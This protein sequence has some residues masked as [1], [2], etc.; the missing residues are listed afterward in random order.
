MSH[1]ER[2][3]YWNNRWTGEGFGW[4]NDQALILVADQVLGGFPG[5][6]TLEVASGRGVD[7]LRLAQMGAGAYVADFSRGALEITRL[8]ASQ[9]KVSIQITQADA[10]R[11]PFASNYFDLVFS[12]GLLEHPGDREEFLREQVRVV[13]PGGY[14]IVDMPNKYCLQTPIRDVQVLL[15]LWPQ[16]KEYPMSYWELKG[17]ME[18]AGLTPIR[19]YGWDLLPLLHLG[20][21]DRM[22]GKWVQRVDQ[23][24]DLPLGDPP[25]PNFFTRN[26]EAKI[27]HWFLNNV[28]VV[29]QKLE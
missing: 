24:K 17:F 11:L 23:I 10:F 26:I 19:A 1:V 8:L 22:R 27:G 16:G 3:G 29:G 18:K 21:R 2:Q 14:V 13:R 12:Q 6:K 25:R 5:K 20:I 15:N 4:Q 7:S 28:G 9:S